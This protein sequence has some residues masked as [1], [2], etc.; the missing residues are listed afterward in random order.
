MREELTLN[1]S[2]LEWTTSSTNYVHITVLLAQGQN[3]VK[4][5]L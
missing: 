5:R 2:E 3:R 1:Y 4:S